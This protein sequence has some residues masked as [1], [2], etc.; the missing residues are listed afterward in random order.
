MLDAGPAA[1]RRPG[2]GRGSAVSSRYSRR[3]RQIQ[4]SPGR[5]P[6]ARASCPAARPAGTSP[7]CSRGRCHGARRPA[8]L[9]QHDG[10]ALDIGAKG[11][12]DEDE[13]R[14]VHD[15]SRGQWRVSRPLRLSAAHHRPAATGRWTLRSGRPGTPSL[16]PGWCGPAVGGMH[17]G[18]YRQDR[19]QGECRLPGIEAQQ[20]RQPA[21]Q[22]GGEERIR[23]RTRQ[24][25]RSSGTCAVPG[26]VKTSSFSRAWAI[27]IRPRLRRSSRMPSW[28][29]GAWMSTWRSWTGG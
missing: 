5:P 12:G 23:Q 13:G 26:S 15:S 18:R 24:S 20:Q 1:R 19:H 27:H 8:L 10:R 4:R 21:Q 16:R 14:R 9:R 29:K 3:S 11:V 7:A 2:A 6:A 25:R 22:F 17:P 28:W